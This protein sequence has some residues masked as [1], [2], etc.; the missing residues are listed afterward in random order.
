MQRVQGRRA[1]LYRVRRACQVMACGREETPAVV[2]LDLACAAPA[3]RQ[4]PT[5]DGL[6]ALSAG[7]H[8]RV[9]VEQAHVVPGPGLQ[10][11]GGWIKAV[12]LVNAGPAVAE[13]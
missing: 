13:H 12:V 2:H 6:D 9:T 8:L 5:D 11:T 3:G 1:L 10:R 7:R 4:R